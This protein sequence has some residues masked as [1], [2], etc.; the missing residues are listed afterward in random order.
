M[1]WESLQLK[2]YGIYQDEALGRFSE[3]PVRLVHFLRAKKTERA[4]DL[5]TGN[6]IIPL[7]ANALYGCPFEGL[8][9][10]E[11]QLRLARLSAER[12]GQTIPFYA[13]DVSE[14]PKFLGRG[15]YDLVTMNPPYYSAASAGETTWDTSGASFRPPFAI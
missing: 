1:R 13:L 10:D 9:L 15:R 12:N 8:D 2:D 11:E 3:D 7:Y 4:L 5:G 6:G 14:A